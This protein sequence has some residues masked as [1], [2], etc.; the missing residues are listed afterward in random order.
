MEALLQAQAGTPEPAPAQLPPSAPAAALSA[1]TQPQP[2]TT[3]IAA[4]SGGGFY[5]QLGAYSQAANAEALRMRL[6]QNWSASLPPLEVVQAGALFR[7][8]SGPFASRADAA[9]AALQIPA[10]GAAQALIVQR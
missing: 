2:V 7:V 3:A 9:G 5:L 4:A 10:A 6:S 1:Q 8:H